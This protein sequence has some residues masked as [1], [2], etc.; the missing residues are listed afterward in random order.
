M[1]GDVGKS[2]NWG[3]RRKGAGR[4]RDKERLAKER[5]KVAR[6]PFQHWAR[7]KS[8]RYDELMALIYDYRCR[9]EEEKGAKT[10][11]RWQ[12]M[13]SFLTEVEKIFGSDYESWIDHEDVDLH[14]N[15]EEK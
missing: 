10:S 2:E 9:L 11:P 4:K 8:G 13:R 7:W 14:F 15:M 12:R 1:S 6:L 3:G 5:T